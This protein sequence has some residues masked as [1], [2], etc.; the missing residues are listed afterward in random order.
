[1]YPYSFY[2]SDDNMMRMLS[3]DLRDEA[4]LNML[5]NSGFKYIRQYH[6]KD[7]KKIVRDPTIGCIV[8]IFKIKDSACAAIKSEKG[9]HIINKSCYF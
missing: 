7:F 9:K 1:M 4:Y 3:I 6:V 2:S 8:E 5:Y